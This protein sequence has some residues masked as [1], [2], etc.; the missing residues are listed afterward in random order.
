MQAGRGDVA[1]TWFNLTVTNPIM[2]TV[3]SLL[4]YFDIVTESERLD[5]RGG[6]REGAGRKP[7]WMHGKTVTIRVPEALA[8]EVLRL[9]RQLD[10]GVQFDSVT[11]SKTIDLSGV[12]IRHLDEQPVIAVKDLLRKGFKIR[13]LK[14]VDALRKEIDRIR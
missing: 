8:S 7:K 10:T 4:R 5:M 14:L 12:P 11:N 6:K 9:A 2:N 13:P 1:V 3:C